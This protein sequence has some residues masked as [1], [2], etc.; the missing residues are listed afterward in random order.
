MRR[1]GVSEGVRSGCGDGLDDARFKSD[2]TAML[3]LR[4]DTSRVHNRGT[5]LTAGV[6]K[7]QGLIRLHVGIWG[8]VCCAAPLRLYM[9]SIATS[10]TA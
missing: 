9:S 5:S 8:T 6:W 7:I 2:W 1:E 10:H 3:A 4:S